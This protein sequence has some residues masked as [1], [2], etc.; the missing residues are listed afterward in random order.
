[1]PKKNQ[2]KKLMS[3]LEIEMNRYN[4]RAST[5][6]K[7]V[8]I[9]SHRNY[10][11]L[12]SPIYEKYYEL[13]ESLIKPGSVVLEIGAGTGTHTKILIDLGASVTAQDISEVSLEAL[14]TKIN[15]D[16]NTITSNM[17]L[18]PI[19]GETFDCIVCC[20]VLSYGSPEKVN[21]EIYRLLKPGGSLIIMD[22][23]NVN[24]IYRFN[25]ILHHLKGERTKST[26]KR[27]PNVNRIKQ[28]SEWFESSTVFYFGY[29]FWLMI[30]I[31]FLLGRSIAVKVNQILEKFKP[32]ATGAF[33]FIFVGRKFIS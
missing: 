22:S 31:K 20:N 23:L 28:F 7:Q 27:I 9:K 30:P 6:L 11:E 25:R 19:S 1:M 12:L 16:I 32:S 26:L 5:E 29:Y 13:I 3:D 33:K 8:S 17:E 18:I 24:C 21:H 10:S 14:R 2:T 15:G 4:Q